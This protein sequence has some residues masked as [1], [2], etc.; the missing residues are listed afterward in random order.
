MK[1]KHVICEFSSGSS[2]RLQD[3]LSNCSK[4]VNNFLACKLRLSVENLEVCDPPCQPQQVLKEFNFYSDAAVRGSWAFVA[5][6]VFNKDGVFVD[7]LTPKVHATS[8]LHAEC[9]ALCHAFSLSLKLNCKDANFFTDYLQLVNVVT[10]F[11]IPV[12]N[13]SNLFLH[14]YSCLK[15]SSRL[16]VSWLPRDANVVA[17]KLAAWAAVNDISRACNERQGRWGK[18]F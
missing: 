8:A 6:V 10:N 13:L 16:S 12:W 17:H 7:A 3:I 9:M 5:V 4:L 1:T 18:S 2:L 14:L 11:S 15:T